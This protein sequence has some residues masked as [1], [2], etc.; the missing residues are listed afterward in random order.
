MTFGLEV[1]LQ[2]TCGQSGAADS[3][4]VARGLQQR[5]WISGFNEDVIYSLASHALTC[6]VPL[7]VTR[8]SPSKY[9]AE[10]LRNQYSL[11]LSL[12][13]PPF[14]EREGSLP[15]SKQPISPAESSP[16]SDTILVLRCN[17]MR[18]PHL[19]LGLPVGCFLQ[20]FW[21]KFC[22][23]FSQRATCPR[24]SYVI[25]PVINET[26]LILLRQLPISEIRDVWDQVWLSYATQSPV[27]SPCELGLIIRFVSEAENP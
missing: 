22:A 4:L 6:E 3:R 7:H 16:Y 19:C 12:N 1:T 21:Q 23:N 24:I 11:T 13:N 2:F 10:S 20:I 17:F 27:A 26:I 5:T 8:N 18:L 14:K 9:G 15:R 25:T